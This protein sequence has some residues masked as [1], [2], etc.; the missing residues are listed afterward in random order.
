MGPI[1]VAWHLVPF[2]PRQ[3]LDGNERRKTKDER[4]KGRRCGVGGTLWL[5]FDF[6][7]FLDVH[8]HDGRGGAAAGF[9]GGDP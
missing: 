4:R 5:G 8:P 3:S 2:L 1:A 7:H 9:G 6:A